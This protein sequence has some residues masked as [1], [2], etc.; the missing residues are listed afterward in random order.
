MICDLDL[1]LAGLSWTFL[2]H[3]QRSRS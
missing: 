3:I 1:W 2:D